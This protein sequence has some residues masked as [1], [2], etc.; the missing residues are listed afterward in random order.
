MSG[1]PVISSLGN[2]TTSQNGSNVRPLL[3]PV[4]HFFLE[5]GGVAF[6]QTSGQSFGA[7]STTQFRTTAKVT[8]TGA[9]KVYAICQGQLF[10]QPHA[11]DNT[12]V[13]VVLKPYKQP[14]N[15]ISIKYF[16]Y[17]G[18]NKSDFLTSDTIPLMAGSETTGTE[19]NKYLWTQ[20]N[21]FFSN[22]SSG[23]PVPSFIAE[24]IGYPS[25][26]LV[27]NVTDKIDHYY[28]KKT[29][30]TDPTNTV[31][32]SDTSYEMPIVP[33][34]IELGSA[35]GEVG[36][37]V[38]LNTGDFDYEGG[39]FPFAYDLA[40]ARSGDHVLDT[41]NG[42]TAYEEKLIKE[43]AINFM[44]VV[45][46]YGMHANGAGKLYVDDI[47]AALETKTDVFG[48]L[49]NF[50]S[51][52][53]QYLYIKGNRQ[54]S[55][56]FYD[57]HV[58]PDST[59]TI[60]IGDTI[61]T[62]SEM[63]YGTNGWPIHVLTNSPTVALQFIV[64]ISRASAYVR[65]GFLT[66]NNSNNFL[67]YEDLFQDE[68]IEPFV[69]DDN[70]TKPI[71][72]AFEVE[73]TTTIASYTEI[74][75]DGSLVTVTEPGET[76]EYGLKILDSIFDLVN[77]TPFVK[78]NNDNDLPVAV[79]YDAQLIAFQE[80]GGSL[81]YGTVKVKRT[82]D[83]ILEVLSNFIERVTYETLLDSIEFNANQYYSSTSSKVENYVAKSEVYEEGANSYYEPS[84]P[85]SIP[86]QDF[87]HGLDWI[88]GLRLVHGKGGIPSKKML[89][90]TKDE[91]QLLVDMITANN[92]NNVRIYFSNTLHRGN[93]YLS[94][95]NV[96]YNIYEIM[97]TGEAF[98]GTF[99]L[100]RPLTTIR[101]FSLDE[102]IF[103]SNNYSRNI[104][105]NIIPNPQIIL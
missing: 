27:Q 88:R 53:K 31:E 41:S 75:Y 34:G 29:T 18:L 92:L 84:S 20:Y 25:A 42:T 16:I 62:L 5:D 80:R 81:T 76:V 66:S 40:F 89:G 74:I 60:A 67:F 54:R 32:T 6:A 26:N 19:L 103:F 70:Y 90:I 95:R 7:V 43:A 28:F 100:Y 38:V 85:Y 72:L 69:T 56:N 87:Q 49:S 50:D 36:I 47:V 102:T 101:V 98:D 30:Y 64:K 11:T 17:R 46:F 3:K 91:N 1:T 13:N 104:P 58:H 8:F 94:P 45:A 61:A 4:S 37:D 79:G 51:K 65:I 63:S 71:E 9:K 99:N 39:V 14:I 21:H 77:V 83:K 52:D 97:L 105:D 22:E 55:Y 2:D 48:Q 15:E 96:K 73:N 86:Y 93:Y 68:N 59:N 24:F 12:K 10:V 82:T 35:T 23:L 78:K 33:R 57:E 44:D